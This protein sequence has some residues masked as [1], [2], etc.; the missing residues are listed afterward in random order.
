MCVALLAERINPHALGNVVGFASANLICSVVCRG[1]PDSSRA[2]LLAEPRE[3]G[4]FAAASVAIGPGMSSDPPGAGW[5]LRVGFPSKL[6][7]CGVVGVRNHVMLPGREKLLGGLLLREK[8]TQQ[9][10]LKQQR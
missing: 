5:A 6:L 3:E 7:L 1:V 2:G 9:L 4:G 8:R 10:L